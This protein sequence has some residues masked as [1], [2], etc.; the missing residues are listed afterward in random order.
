MAGQTD[1]NPA[2]SLCAAYLKAAMIR[3]TGE[4]HDLTVL[5]AEN[6]RVIEVWGCAPSLLLAEVVG[7]RSIS[8]ALEAMVDPLA[9]AIGPT[10][11]SLST[12][13]AVRAP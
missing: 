6:S 12:G 13:E 3:V 9:A 4:R 11:G 1:M 10:T 5:I 7:G 2:E 8:E